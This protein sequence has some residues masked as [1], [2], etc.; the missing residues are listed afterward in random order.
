MNINNIE[1]VYRVV[2]Y[3]FNKFDA[4]NEMEAHNI[5]LRFFNKY[6]KNYSVRQVYIA[7]DLIESKYHVYIAY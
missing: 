4:I 5:A 1:E 6:Y 7:F 2:K 3:S